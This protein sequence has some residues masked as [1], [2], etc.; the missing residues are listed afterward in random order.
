LIFKELG[1]GSSKDKDKKK[2]KNR[3]N[4]NMKGRKKNLG[5]NKIKG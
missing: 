3:Y 4:C 2:G 1:E 5:K